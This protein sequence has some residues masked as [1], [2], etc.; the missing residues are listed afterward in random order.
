MNKL[1]LEKH[2]SF[3]LNRRSSVLDV[4]DSPPT[5]DTEPHEMMWFEELDEMEFDLDANDDWT[6]YQ[7][8]MTVTT[9]KKTMDKLKDLR[10]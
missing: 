9:M 3:M 2:E 10:K 6:K 8:Y 5:T 4:G 1:L 7:E